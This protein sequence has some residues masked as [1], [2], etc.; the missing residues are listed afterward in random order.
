MSATPPQRLVPGALFPP[1]I[2]ASKSAQKRK[3]K[4]GGSTTAVD[5]TSA[6]PS[7]LAGT[8][9]LEVVTNGVSNRGT[10]P[11]PSTPAVDS[12][13]LQKLS[14]IVDLINKRLKAT[15]KKV[16]CTSEF[17]NRVCRL[18]H[19]SSRTETYQGV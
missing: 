10:S 6:T 17:K 9:N 3:K 7:P 14:P 8:Q 15:Q 19:A 5:D 18:G 1:Q 11:A 2:S 4:A 16:V 12:P 13:S